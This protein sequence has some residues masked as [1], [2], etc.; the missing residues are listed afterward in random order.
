M[1]NSSEPRREPADVRAERQALLAIVDGA[2]PKLTSDRECA[3]EREIL[4]RLW[5][6]VELQQAQ[7][8]PAPTWRRRLVCFIE[9]I[10]LARMSR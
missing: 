5:R 1:V 3:P 7:A 6:T 10:G 9:R 2:G 8:P 4:R